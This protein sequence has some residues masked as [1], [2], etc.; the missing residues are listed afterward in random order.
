MT[1][2]L[3]DVC[4]GCIEAIILPGPGK[5]CGFLGY[6]AEFIIPYQCIRKVGPDIILVEIQ[7]DKCLK[8]C[9]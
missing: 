9:K 2:L 8:G 5:I 4:S 3:I 7:E 6:D 1:D